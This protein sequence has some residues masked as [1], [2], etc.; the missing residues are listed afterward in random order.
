MQKKKKKPR[1]LMEKEVYSPRK[2]KSSKSNGVSESRGRIH[3][4]GYTSPKT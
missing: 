4:R 2:S 3:K 1:N